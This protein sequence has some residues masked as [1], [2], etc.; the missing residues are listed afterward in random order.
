MNQVH[1][2]KPQ[3]PIV[4]IGLSLICL[5]MLVLALSDS[6]FNVLQSLELGL[7]FACVVLINVAHWQATRF[8]RQAYRELNARS[9][10]PEPPG[11]EPA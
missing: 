10:S 11:Q 5:A 2:G 7:G 4:V 8:G 6:K 9:A 3:N 1:L